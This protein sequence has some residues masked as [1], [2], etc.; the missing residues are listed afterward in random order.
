MIKG[1]APSIFNNRDNLIVSKVNDETFSISKGIVYVGG[2]IVFFEGLSFQAELS[3]PF[4]I[5]IEIEGLPSSSS[6]MQ[7]YSIAT[8]GS[9][10]RP[11]DVPYSVEQA[12]TPYDLSKSKVVPIAYNFDNRKIKNPFKSLAIVE[13][14][15]E[16]IIIKQHTYG[17]LVFIPIQEYDYK[18]DYVGIRTLGGLT[19]SF[20]L[21][22][23]KRLFLK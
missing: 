14:K 2:N 16:K 23:D 13:Q 6:P 22:I 18:D 7:S 9:S 19:Y 4:R 21:N 20:Y 17:P 8:A 3:F 11:A 10:I 15:K 1:K 12:P 5:G